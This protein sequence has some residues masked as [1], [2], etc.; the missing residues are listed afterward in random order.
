MQQ[1]FA[2]F[3]KKKVP[4]FIDFYICNAY[5]CILSKNLCV[6]ITFLICLLLCNVDR[7]WS[8]TA[9][10]IFN[11]K[12]TN[13]NR[14]NI[15]RYKKN[16]LLFLSVKIKFSKQ[17]KHFVFNR[18]VHFL[19]YHFSL[20]SIDRNLINIFKKA[21]NTEKHFAVSWMF[22]KELIML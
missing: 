19:Q 7:H 11:P 20:F 1:F 15:K 13:N 4:L 2:K 16:T 22:I 18:L 17:L 8:P 10:E 9:L 14:R 12:Q 21:Y 3:Q 5:K 6:L